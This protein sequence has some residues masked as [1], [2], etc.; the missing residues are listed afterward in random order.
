MRKRADGKNW[1]QPSTATCN[2]SFPILQ[3]RKHFWPAKCPKPSRFNCS[4]HP[5]A[6][7]SNLEYTIYENKWETVYGVPLW[8][9]GF[10]HTFHPVTLGLSPKHT[11]FAFII[12]SRI[13][14]IFV[15]ALWKERKLNKKRRAKFK[16][17]IKDR[18][19]GYGRRLTS[20]RSWVRIP[21]LDTGWTFFNIYLL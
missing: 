5:A 1:N 11:L 16:A 6:P 17:P 9:S 2:Q 10:V 4:F 14:A 8:L 3:T 7:G 19:S 15:F 21:V 13:C 20:K 18:S 12:C